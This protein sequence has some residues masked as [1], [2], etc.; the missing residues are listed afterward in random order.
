MR[1]A[2][3]MLVF[4]PI[5]VV[6]IFLIG[7]GGEDVAK[8]DVGDLDDSMAKLTHEDWKVRREGENDIVAASQQGIEVT[9]GLKRLARDINPDVREEA[10]R[11]LTLIGEGINPDLKKTI[12]RRIKDLDTTVDGAPDYAVTEKAWNE[13][14]GIGKPAVPFLLKR[15][16]DQGLEWGTIP[17]L[18]EFKDRRMIELYVAVLRKWNDIRKEGVIP[19]GEV[20]VRYDYNIKTFTEKT[21][22]TLE[23]WYRE[24]RHY[25]YW[26]D[27][28]YMF[29]VD[30][31]AKK[32]AIPTG[33]Y[34]SKNPRSATS[35][36][37]IA[38]LIE[39]LNKGNWDV[40]RA[41]AEAL[42][43]IT[44]QDFGYDYDKWKAWHEE[45]K[46]K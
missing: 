8:K 30:E 14:V 11:V 20:V 27:D 3:H 23:H 36:V 21:F 46:Q 6:A 2:L 10:E 29:L 19:S 41:A 4:T 12:N 33:L 15:A 18:D 1:N 25:I 22:D 35:D 7:C 13:L 5:V 43:K 24:N 26:S 40:T 45:N 39:R 38:A 9:S 34:T 17:D 32:A 28:A 44:G 16:Y 42:K 37:T 31:G